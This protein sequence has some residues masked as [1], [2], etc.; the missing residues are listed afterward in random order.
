MLTAWP[1]REVV[2]EERVVGVGAASVG[3]DAVVG[4]PGWRRAAA[5][6]DRRSKRATSRAEL[7][8][9]MRSG[10]GGKVVRTGTAAG[11]M[12]TAEETR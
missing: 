4:G 8:R 9:V 3:G 2:R 7:W 1:R 6:R 12:T 5:L 11:V 10:G